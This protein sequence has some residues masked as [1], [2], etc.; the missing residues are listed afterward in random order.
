M[1]TRP[2]PLNPQNLSEE[3]KKRQAL[4]ERR[5]DVL[6][7]AGALLVAF[8]F[9]CIHHYLAPIAMGIFCLI[10][11]LLEL[12]KSFIRGLRAPFGGNRR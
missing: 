1:S 8:G 4:Q 9:G 2:I 11:P 10:F 6:Y 12:A 5:S 3:Q 7:I